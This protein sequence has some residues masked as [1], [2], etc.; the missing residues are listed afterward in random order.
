MKYLY[1]Y[2][3][4][5]KHLSTPAELQAAIDGNRREGRRTSYGQFET[6]MQQQQHQL[7]MV[8]DDDKFECARG[9]ATFSL[10]QPQMQRSPIPSNIQQMSPLSLVTHGN[11]QN[12]HRLMGAPPVG[13]LPGIVPHEFEQRMLD[14]IKLFQAPKDI[15]REL[16]R[17]SL[18]FADSHHLSS[19][20]GPQSP[21][22][23]RDALTALEMSRMAIWS[24]YQNAS[25]P[26]QQHTSPP[27]V[28]REALNLQRESPSP[29]PPTQ[30]PIISIKR[31]RD[32]SELSDYHVPP[33][34]K[35]SLAGMIRTNTD[36]S[37]KS[38]IMNNNHHHIINNNNAHVS[39]TK[40]TSKPSI[41]RMNSP[42]IENGRHNRSP[43]AHHKQQPNGLDN[44]GTTMLNG[45]QFKIIS[46]GKSTRAL[47]DGRFD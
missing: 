9:T 4:E 47:L 2:E 11:P 36:L 30:S 26:N 38:S 12:Q 34:K 7:Q 43:Q 39:P 15:K 16:D 33:A 28:Q 35:P 46:K 21:D 29:I 22:N 44:L 20:A 10:L 23:P 14:Y 37:R 19:L 41:D 3:C 5:K 17:R 45:M 6:Q 27:E 25:P 1:P 31:E 42:T 32:L 24:M 18:G 13:H 40:V 8:S